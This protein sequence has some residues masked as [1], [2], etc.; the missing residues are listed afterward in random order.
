MRP[1]KRLV[2]M[3]AYVRVCIE[4]RLKGGVWAWDKGEPELKRVSMEG[5]VLRE[6]LSPKPLHPKPKGP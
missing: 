1:F 5:I 3:D 6:T 2:D 4:F